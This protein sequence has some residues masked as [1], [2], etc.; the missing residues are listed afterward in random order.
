[1]D[2]Q[3]VWIFPPGNQTP[4]LGVVSHLQLVLELITAVSGLKCQ[5]PTT[6][7]ERNASSDSSRSTKKNDAV[8]HFK[9]RVVNDNPFSSKPDASPTSKKLKSESSLGKPKLVKAPTKGIA[10]AGP[11]PRT[12][13]NRASA[14]SGTLK[15]SEF[16]DIIEANEEEWSA[17]ETE[18]NEATKEGKDENS[19]IE[20]SSK[21]DSKA[22]EDVDLDEVDGF[23]N[24]DVLVEVEDTNE[25]TK[26]LLACLLHIFACACISILICWNSA[27]DTSYELCYFASLLVLSPEE[28]A[29]IEEWASEAFFSQVDFRGVTVRSRLAK[30][31]GKFFECVGDINVSLVGLSLF[32]CGLIFKELKL[33]LNGMEHISPL[34]FTKH[35]LLCWRDIISNVAALGVSVGS[36][37]KRL[38]VLRDIM[39]GLQLEKEKGVLDQFIKVNKLM[40]ALEFQHKKLKVEKLKLKKLVRGSSKEITACLQLV[41]D[42]L[43]ASTSSSS[44]EKWCFELNS[45]PFLSCALCMIVCTFLTIYF[46]FLA[47]REP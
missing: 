15:P 5:C 45:L 18:G 47:E 12:R 10:L 25:V 40:C 8:K 28:R 31:L 6:T 11:A 29:S 46:F 30:V 38:G 3:G 41:A 23:L 7:E 37:V 13:S 17:G 34:E 9:L 35:R 36:L 1:M 39:F 22:A 24:D 44:S 16:L 26:L 27:L 19:S 21:D 43:H 4:L 33:L 14:S 42:Q 2:A 20:P 32:M